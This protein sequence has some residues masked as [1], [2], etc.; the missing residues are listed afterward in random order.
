M[1][2]RMFIGAMAGGLLTAP[3]A[4]EAQQAARVWR[5]G[6]LM[7]LYSPDANPPQALRRGLHDLG[8]VEGRNLVIDWRYQLGQSDRLRALAVELVRLKP[9]FIV[10]DSTVATRA[11]LQATSTI[12]I[13]MAASADAVGTGL[14]TSLARP[15]GNVS[16]VTI[17]LAEMSASGFSSSRKR[18]RARRE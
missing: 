12:P 18:C 11:A 16:G 10:A 15:G 13:V 6:V 7:D 1:N 9:E 17:M 8:Y 14:V 3:L 2:R 4:T 5:I